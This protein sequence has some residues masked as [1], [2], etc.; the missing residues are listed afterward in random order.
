MTSSEQGM[1]QRFLFENP[2]VFVHSGMAAAHA[3]EAHV[4]GHTTWG[5]IRFHLAR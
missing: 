3:L 2:L 4:S 1:A 5:H